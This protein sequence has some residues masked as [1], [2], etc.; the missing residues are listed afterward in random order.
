M[1]LFL[2]DKACRGNRLNA[3]EACVLAA[4][5][6]CTRAGRGWYGNYGDLAAALPFVISR[7][8]VTRAV[9][10]LFTLGLVVENENGTLLAVQNGLPPTPPIT[11]N[12][13]KEGRDFRA[14]HAREKQP[15][16]SFEDFKDEFIRHGGKINAWDEIEAHNLWRETSDAKKVAL[17]TAMREGKCIKPKINWTVSDF[18]EPE[19]TNYNGKRSMPDVPLVTAKYNGK[20]GIYTAAE[21]QLFG[22]TDIKNFH[23]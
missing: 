8:T 14:L 9:Q 7:Q 5:L 18:P 10:K 2:D 19:P 23:H 17:V 12:S 15:I 16:P 11:N 20:Y 22:M 3:N 21:A 4:I 13:M 6:K 1:R